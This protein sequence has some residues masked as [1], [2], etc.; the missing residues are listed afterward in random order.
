MSAW[1][2]F[3]GYFLASAG[4][5]YA[6]SAE[7]SEN[8]EMLTVPIQQLARVYRYDKESLDSE[9]L[10]ALYEILPEDVLARYVPKVSDGVKI[11]FRND[12][13]AADPIRYGKLWLKTGIRHPFTYLNAW[14][15]TSYGFWY[16]DTVIDVYKGNSVFTFT[17]EDSSFSVMRWN[18]LGRGKVRFP[19]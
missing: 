5:A 3:V 17:Y 8:Q 19:G 7:D 14:F 13:F 1:G 2:D 11:G 16:P 6:F 10:E 12:A 4:L 18:S 9:D 15:M